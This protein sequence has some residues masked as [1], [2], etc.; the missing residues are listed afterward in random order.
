M[1]CMGW[2][3]RAKVD[4]D[5]LKERRELSFSRSRCLSNIKLSALALVLSFYVNAHS[6]TTRHYWKLVF[7]LSFTI[8]EL[9]RSSCSIKTSEDDDDTL[10][11]STSPTFIT[12]KLLEWISMCMT[13]DGWVLMYKLIRKSL[14]HLYTFSLF[15]LKTKSTSTFAT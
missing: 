5:F 15:L 3:I 11:C 14:Y 8:R 9:C 2:C 12:V 10:I 7:S 1:L 4:D 13:I 6:T